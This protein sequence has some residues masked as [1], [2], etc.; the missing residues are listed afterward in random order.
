MFYIFSS[1]KNLRHVLDSSAPN[2]NEQRESVMQVLGRIGVSE[3]KF[4][5][6]IEVWN[7]VNDFNSLFFVFEFR[8]LASSN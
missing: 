5:N 1:L 2:I 7:K 6:I 3:D 4:R 8:T